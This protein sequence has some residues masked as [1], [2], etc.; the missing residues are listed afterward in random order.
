LIALRDFG[1]LLGEGRTVQ[2]EKVSL[3]RFDSAMLVGWSQG[4]WT[5]STLVAEGF[6]VDPTRHGHGVYGGAIALD[7]AGNWLAVNQ[8]GD[9]GGPQDP[10][11][12]PNGDPLTP[13]QML[14]RRASDPLFV[15][16]A[17]YTD[18]ACQPIRT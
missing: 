5:V 18:F 15:D 10:Y 8:L 7:G 3:G 6:N 12:R 1:R 9:D 4:A 13:S 16:I 17:A 11:V 2:G 14:T